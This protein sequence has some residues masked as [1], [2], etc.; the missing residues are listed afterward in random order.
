MP[1]W[2]AR[3]S[4]PLSVTLRVAPSSAPSSVRS[5]SSSSYASG[6]DAR[7]DADDGVRLGEH[8]EV[9]VA[10]AGEDADAAAGRQRDRRTDGRGR[11]AVAGRE[12]RQHAGAHRRHLDRRRAVDRGDELAAE[13]GLP[14]DEPVV[15]A[16]EVDRVAGEPGAELRGDARRD[17]AAPR[18]RAGE[19]RPRLASRRAQP[20]TAA[21]T[22]SSTFSPSRCTIASAPHEPSSSRVGRL[23]R[24]TRRSTL[25]VERGAPR[26]GARGS[27]CARSGS[28]TTDRSTRSVGA[29]AV[30]PVA[31]GLVRVAAS[32]SAPRSCSSAHRVAHLLGERRV[33][34]ACRR[35]R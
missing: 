32:C 12:R 31:R 11:R 14:R 18:R 34:R 15:A 9:V 6:G 20:A 19:D 21:A 3:G 25:P 23:R 4:Q 13:R 17:L 35:A 28:T 2:R 33:G 10:G 30:R 16:F 29:G 8:V 7:A 5:G 27:S 24:V 26:R 22:S 1:I